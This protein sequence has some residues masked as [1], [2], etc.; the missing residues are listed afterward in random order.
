MAPHFSSA[1][2]IMHSGQ[3]YCQLTTGNDYN[4]T[5]VEKVIVLYLSKSIALLYYLD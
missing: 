3:S 4:V 2:R 1:G 5:T